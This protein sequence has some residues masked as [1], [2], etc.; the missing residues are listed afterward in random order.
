M[1]VLSFILAFGFVFAAP[2]FNATTDSTLPGAGAFTYPAQPD[3]ATTTAH[4]TL[5]TRGK[6]QPAGTQGNVRDAA[7]NVARS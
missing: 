1:R 3:T 2:G 7:T 5:T 6:A 4:L